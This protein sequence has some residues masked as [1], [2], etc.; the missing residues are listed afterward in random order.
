MEQNTPMIAKKIWNL[1]RVAFFM[2]RKGICKRK[3]LLDINLVMKRGKIAGKALQNLMFHHQHQHRHQH[4]HQ[5]Q[6]Q[7]QGFSFEP[8]TGGSPSHLQYEFSC[9]STPLYHHYFTN[10]KKHDL[11]NN[12]DFFYTP[13][14]SLEELKSSDAFNNDMFGMVNSPRND[15]RASQAVSGLGLGLN[16]GVRQLRIT[17]SPFPV[18]NSDDGDDDSHVDAAAEDF[19]NKFYSQLKKQKYN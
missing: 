18:Q 9:R 6:R 7:H 16:A 3:L 17:D 13:Y 8:D 2:L 5:H 10:K 19:I 12:L 1:I 14:T 15:S 11:K 4:Q